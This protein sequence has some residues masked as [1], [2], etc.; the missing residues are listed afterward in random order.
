MRGRS[1]LMVSSVGDHDGCV[2]ATYVT[3]ERRAALRDFKWGK[4][5]IK[6]ILFVD[7]DPVLLGI[8]SGTASQQFGTEFEIQTAEGG[9]AA[10]EVTDSE[11]PFSVVVVDM[12]MPGMN[13]IE[14][15]GHLRTKMPHAVFMMLTANR[16]LETA[17]HA[18][19]DGKVFKFLSKPCEPSELASSIKAA[20]SEHNSLVSAKDLLSGTI[21]GTLDLM[22]DLIEMPDGRHIDTARMLNAT[23]DLASRMAINLGWEERIAARVFLVGIA[24]LSPQEAE[25]FDC[26][27]PTSDE[28]KEL[29]GKI[30][31]VSAGLLK[32]IPRFDWIVDL[33]RLVPKAERYR[34][35]GSREELSALVLRVVFYWNF[36]TMKGMCVET[37][38]A[39]IR[40]IM[41][42]LP[43]KLIGAV[44]CLH[45]NRDAL[46]VKTVAMTELKPGMIPYHSVTNDQGCKVI[47]GGRRLTQAMIDNLCADRE[48]SQRPLMVVMSSISTLQYDDASGV[49]CP[50]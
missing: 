34:E 22:T 5:M 44:E 30:C 43:D 23:S 2:H 19:N 29:F 16:D 45:D 38:S 39:T 41:P 24:M 42:E 4:I 10:I 6:K 50:V 47:S 17:I 14:T 25:R 40:K 12:Q 8:L 20:Q 28:H 33:L 46:C 35:L 15:I 36:L 31:R 1:S 13:G 27:D 37:A 11:G 48:L 7:D 9:Q 3:D 18:V 32:K 26:L 21:S 49:A